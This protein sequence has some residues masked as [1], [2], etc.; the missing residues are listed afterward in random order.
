MKRWMITLAAGVMA[1]SLVVPALAAPGAP[2]AGKQARQG[3]QGRKGGQRGMKRLQGALA[4]L[5]LTA[6]QKTKIDALSEATKAE[7]KKIQAGSGTP[8]EKRP[9]MRAAMRAFREKLNAILTPEQ[10]KQLREEMQKGRKKNA[11]AK[12]GKKPAKAA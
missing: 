5:N 1:A 9:K 2:G 3:A 6:D 10:Q 7:V 8:E 4:K 12:T 11:R